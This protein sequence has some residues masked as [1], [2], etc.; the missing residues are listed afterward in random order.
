MMTHHHGRMC[1]RL[2][3]MMA[4]AAASWASGAA[5]APGEPWRAT[6]VEG[7]ATVRRGEGPPAA[8]AEGRVLEPGDGLATGAA[9]RVVLSRGASTITVGP[10]GRMEI[11]TGGDDGVRTRI[12][13]AMGSLL[14]KVEKRASRHFEVETP[15]LAAVVKGTTFTVSVEG[16]TSA[17]HVVEGAVEVKALATGQ[18]G[19]VKPGYTA[20]VSRRGGRGLSIIGGKPEASGKLGKG[21]QAEEPEREAEEAGR[22][23]HAAAPGQEKRLHTMLGQ[24]SVDVAATSKGFVRNASLGNGHHRG[25]EHALASANSG[26]G[27][28]KG[29]GKEKSNNG[30]SASS[31]GAAKAGVGNPGGG[32]A[33]GLAKKAGTAVSGPVAKADKAADK[34][35]AA[36]AKAREKALKK[37]TKVGGSESGDDDDDDDD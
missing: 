13:Q 34:V 33:F 25:A 8:V 23:G 29:L 36:A 19:L 17:V 15:Y 4:F 18:V 37:K 12:V 6:A 1:W 2:L 32:N 24:A 27:L 16:E 35:L 22:A 5:A 20:V 26:S 9:G 11:P 31:P 14:F 30:K 28:A 7:E 21:E 10:N 3:I